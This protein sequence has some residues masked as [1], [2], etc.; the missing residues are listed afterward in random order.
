MDEF[1]RDAIRRKIHRYEEKK[2]LTL[3][4]IHQVLEEDDLFHGGRSSLAKELN[5][6]GF[7]YKR[8]N[9]KR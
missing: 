9:N 5:R 2:H 6:M 8:I 7:T 1:D 4:V 3:N